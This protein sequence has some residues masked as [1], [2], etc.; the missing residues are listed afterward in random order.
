MKLHLTETLCIAALILSPFNA[1]LDMF[2]EK[3]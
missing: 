3:E 2:F 1:A